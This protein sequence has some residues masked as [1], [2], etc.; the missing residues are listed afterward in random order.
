[1][2]VRCFRISILTNGAVNSCS[3]PA[4]PR[5]RCAELLG[6]SR[7]SKAA[8]TAGQHIAFLGLLRQPPWQKLAVEVRLSNI[9]CF[10]CLYLSSYYLPESEKG[11]TDREA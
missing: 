2:R 10:L 11:D 8:L 3:Q 4:D 9:L 5:E 7:N 1:M 6:K